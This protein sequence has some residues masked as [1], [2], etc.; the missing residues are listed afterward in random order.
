MKKIAKEKLAKINI[1]HECSVC[2]KSRGNHKADTMQ[3]PMGRKD[4]TLGYS[5]YSSTTFVPDPKW[6]KPPGSFTI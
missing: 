4:R 3:C 2:G 6:K 1:M 5:S